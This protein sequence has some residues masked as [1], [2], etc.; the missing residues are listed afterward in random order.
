MLGCSCSVCVI[1]SVSRVVP[2]DTLVEL[3]A[4]LRDCAGQFYVNL[5]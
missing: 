2:R 5:T 4:S 3:V 1:L